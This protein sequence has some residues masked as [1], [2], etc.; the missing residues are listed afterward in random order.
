MF[1]ERAQVHRTRSTII[2]DTANSIGNVESTPHRLISPPIQYY[3][4]V[5]VKLAKSANGIQQALAGNPSLKTEI[6]Y[7]NALIFSYLDLASVRL[8]CV[9]YY[10]PPW[11]M[12]FSSHVGGM[13]SS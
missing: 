4:H 2:R 12:L 10:L 7:N 6:S 13:T 5:L 8:F 9:S 1:R 11:L 3:F